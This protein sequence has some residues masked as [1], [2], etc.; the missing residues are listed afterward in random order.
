MSILAVPNGISAMS[1][2][3]RVQEIW[4]HKINNPYRTMKHGLL[5]GL[6]APN[7]MGLSLEHVIINC[8]QWY[9][10]HV[11]RGK[12]AGDTVTKIYPRAPKL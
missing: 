12:G 10:F 4:S 11:R 8:V 9:K 1:I 2:G 5:Q 6:T 7:E 3:C